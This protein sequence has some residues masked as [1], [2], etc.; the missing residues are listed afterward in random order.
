MTKTLMLAVSLTLCGV[1]DSN[2]QMGSD[3]NATEYQDMALSEAEKSA[4]DEFV[5]SNFP[6]AG[7][8]RSLTVSYSS[9]GCFHFWSETMMIE[10]GKE[11]V[12]VT[13]AY[14]K[15]NGKEPRRNARYV[16]PGSLFEYAMI[17]LNSR[18]GSLLQREQQKPGSDNK[19]LESTTVTML[20]IKDNSH[21]VKVSVDENGVY[22]DFKRTLLNERYRKTQFGS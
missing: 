22:D 21:S 6:Y 15:R 11:N 12:T 3:L 4:S 17:K 10:K 9:Y 5:R 20:E 2:R 14:D 7:M 18:I 13:I 8:S 16:V 19:M 1:N